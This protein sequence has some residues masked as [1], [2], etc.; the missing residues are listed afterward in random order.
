VQS[1]Q[2]TRPKRKLMLSRT[3]LQVLGSSAP[4]NTNAESDSKNV[5]T[6]AYPA[7]LAA[8]PAPAVTAPVRAR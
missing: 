5:Q 8:E 3:T 6:C 7:A 4:C 1:D 2:A